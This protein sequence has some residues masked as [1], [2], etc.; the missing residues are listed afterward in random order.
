MACKKPFSAL[1]AEWD[2]RLEQTGFDDIE[3]RYGRLKSPDT[4]TIS[5]EDREA[6]LE[7]YLALDAFLNANKLP[8]RDRRILELH[9]CGIQTVKIAGMTK[10]PLRTVKWLIRRYKLIILGQNPPT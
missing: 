8:R 1:K 7:F 9:S 3:D 2:L 5:F 4:R 10:V 6:V